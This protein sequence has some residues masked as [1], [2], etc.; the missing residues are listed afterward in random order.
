M[1]L[2][3][4]GFTLIELLVV[5]AIIGILASVVLVGLTS[6]RG[7]ANAAATKATLSSLRSGIAI[8]CDDPSHKLNVWDGTASAPSLC[9]DSNDNTVDIG[10]ILPDGLALRGGA[11]TDVSYVAGTSPSTGILCSGANPGLDVTID[12]HPVVACQ[13][14]FH[15]TQTQVVVPSGC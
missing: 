2:F 6:A 7:K 11:A 3:K 4:K 1:K 5:I 9:A 15:I 13:A 10:V 14:A 8:C 12:T